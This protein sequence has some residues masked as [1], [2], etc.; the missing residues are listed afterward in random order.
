MSWKSALS[1]SPTTT[2]VRARTSASGIAS[3]KIS[4]EAAVT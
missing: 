3:G 1:F 2:S 4:S